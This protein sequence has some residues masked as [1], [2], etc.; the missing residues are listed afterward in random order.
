MAFLASAMASSVGHVVQHHGRAVRVMAK[1][2]GRQVEIQRAANPWATTSR[3]R[4][5]QEALTL[6]CTRRSSCCLKSPSQPRGRLRQWPHR[7]LQ[8]RARVPVRGAAVPDH[9]ESHGGEVFVEAGGLVILV[10]TR[11]GA[12]V[13]TQGNAEA[14]ARA[15]RASR[16]AA[17]ITSVRR[18]GVRGDGR[19]VHAAVV[20]I[21]Q[22]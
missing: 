17:S 11:H 8:A 12:G 16:P 7:S 3:G 21:V 10:T 5:K 15:L 1:G 20:Q 13:L 2:F 19:D 14:W 6:L 4:R 9:V 18:V 22:P